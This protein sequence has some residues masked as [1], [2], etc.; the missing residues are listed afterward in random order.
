MIREEIGCMS[1]EQ[2]PCLLC[3]SLC[4]IFVVVE[5]LDVR[6]LEDRLCQLYMVSRQLE[7][8]SAGFKVGHYGFLLHDSLIH[9]LPCPQAQGHTSQMLIDPVQSCLHDIAEIPVRQWFKVKPLEL[10]DDLENP[11]RRE[12][13]DESCL[14]CLLNSI[15]QDCITLFHITLHKIEEGKAASGI[16]VSE[17]IT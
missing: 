12:L 1:A 2:V 9:L 6:H 17:G 5:E 13:L 11:W 16:V 8:C 4:C 15:Q 3:I 14:L 10:I 7:V